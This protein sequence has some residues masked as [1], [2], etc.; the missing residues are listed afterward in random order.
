MS[1]TRSITELRKTAWIIGAQ[2]YQLRLWRNGTYFV[3]VPSGEGTEVP[4]E[5]VA[6]AL[7]QLFKTFF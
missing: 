6:G 7:A 3:E 1:E 4:E 5:A 2:G